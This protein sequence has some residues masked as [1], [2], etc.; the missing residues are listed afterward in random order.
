MAKDYEELKTLSDN[1]LQTMYWTLDVDA[2][3]G[4]ELF[5]R[6]ESELDRRSIGI[7]HLC[8]IPNREE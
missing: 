7:A 8:E 6:V 4:V 3:G 1:E 5:R 2:D